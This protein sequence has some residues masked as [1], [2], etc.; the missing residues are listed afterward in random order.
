ML[1]PVIAMLHNTKMNR[2]HPIFFRE[3]PLPGPPGPDK[4]IRHQSSGHHTEGFAT[5]EEAIANIKDDLKGRIERH[6]GG[7]AEMCLDRDFPWDGEDVPAITVYF[8]RTEGK[9]VPALVS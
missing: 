1:N 2:W 7:T 8:A 4:P 6:L 5:R 3:K 9:I